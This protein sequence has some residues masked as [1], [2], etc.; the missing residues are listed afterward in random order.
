MPPLVEV[1]EKSKRLPEWRA[2]LVAEGVSASKVDKELNGLY[3]SYRKVA[4]DRKAT[5]A[6]KK[7]AVKNN[8]D[9]TKIN[10]GDGDEVLTAD[11]FVRQFE[12]KVKVT[13][14]GKKQAVA[15]ASADIL[16]KVA[17]K[18]QD[19]RVSVEECALVHR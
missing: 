5:A 2:T 11:E 10:T 1:L 17:D 19:G 16:R 13:V 14:D 18:N 12:K 8:K 3:V 6:E 7:Y 4:K 9:P 15:V